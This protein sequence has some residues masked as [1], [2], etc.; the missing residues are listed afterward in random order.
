L[1]ALGL[2]MLCA[3]AS[4][5]VAACGVALVLPT[6][7][8]AQANPLDSL[9]IE[10]R[11]AARKRD[12]TRL[13]AARAALQAGGHPLTPWVEYWDLS[14]RLNE[15]QADEVEAFYARWPGSYVED[16]LRNDW[17]LELGRRRDWP[18]LARDYPRFRMNDDREVSCWWLFT[19]HLAGRDVR[20]AARTAWFNQKELDDGCNLLATAMV[21]AKRFTVDDVW[22]KARLALEAQ[23]PL[24]AKAAVGLLGNAAAREVVEAIDNPARYLRRNSGSNANSALLPQE[25]RLL[26]LLR[27]ALT[28][29]DSATGLLEGGSAGLSA[30]QGAWA[31]A[32]AGR[33]AAFKLAPDAAAYYQRALGLLR[34]DEARNPG[35]TDDT[36]AWGVRATLR[37]AAPA[38]RW[39]QVQ[40]L[41]DLMSP[42][43]QREPVWTYWKARALQAQARDGAEGEPQRAEARRLLD[44]ITGGLNFYASLATE[45]LGRTP[46]L[47]AAPAA[48]SSSERDAAK[49]NPGLNRA[50]LLVDL[51]LRDEARREW[52]FSLRGMGDRELLAAARWACDRSDW[53]LCIN[54]A[55]RTRG[56]IDT[57]LRY[58]MPFTAAITQAANAAGLDPA[59]VFG[60][61]R[62]ETRFMPQLKSSVGAAGLM[63]VMPA[64]GR[65]VA[66][67]IG[68]DWRNPEVISDPLVNLRLGTSY[69]KLVLDDLGGSQAMAAA[70]YNAG[71]GRPRRWREGPQLETAIWAENIPFKETRDY[72]KKVLSNA[73]V[74]SA[75]IDSQKPPLLRPR[76]GD[77]IGPRD[78][79]AATNTEL[80]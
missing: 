78:A 75:L 17:L 28:D 62:Q 24:A 30:S 58:P 32:Y 42:S 3:P 63:Q 13:A 77:G 57:A 29:L 43:E 11:D 36:L 4:L 55:E 31:W 54:T 59:L 22:R 23:R 45:D 15:A 72:V 5:L 34:G 67:K 74:Y 38:L 76:L 35:W 47:P 27:L 39:R 8:V 7:A 33:Q 40:R 46:A 9:V 69:L 1:G 80:P 44:S 71:P 18:A 49:T 53:Q 10:A 61:I 70:A 25:M 60:L 52:N 65:W 16:R 64:T 12:R 2:I 73:S 21:D 66:K 19:E 51:G 79:A 20:D 48:L 41:V 68:M 37:T 56:E 14:T 50:L 6:P 26:A